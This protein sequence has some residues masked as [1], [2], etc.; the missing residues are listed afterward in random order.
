MLLHW[1][2]KQ[3]RVW[4]FLD[5]SSI[6]STITLSHTMIH[7]KLPQNSSHP[8]LAHSKEHN[9]GM[10]FP[11][12]PISTWCRH[13]AVTC[14]HF[15]MVW[16]TQSGAHRTHL[17]DYW[18]GPSTDKLVINILVFFPI[19]KVTTFKINFLVASLQSGW[20]LASF[21]TNH[22]RWWFIKTHLRAFCP[23]WRTFQSSLCQDQTC[24]SKPHII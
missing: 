24:Y 15:R 16:N 23:F 5:R 11:W 13:D 20:R 1:R 18:V 10:L 8:E 2:P 19:S 6:C 12:N 7:T 17:E 21:L 14:A 9:P 4:M 3:M 22:Q